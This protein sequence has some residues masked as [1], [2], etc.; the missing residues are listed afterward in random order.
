MTVSMSAAVLASPG[1]CPWLPT[2]EHDMEDST[3][4][5]FVKQKTLYQCP[6]M[7]VQDR[8]PFGSKSGR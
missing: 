4:F 3:L 2:T 5:P 8:V 7:F 6:G 1:A